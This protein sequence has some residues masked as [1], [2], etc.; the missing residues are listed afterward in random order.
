MLH[1]A[2]EETKLSSDIHRY[3]KKVHDTGDGT[4]ST[5]DQKQVL[6][7]FYLVKKENDTEENEEQEAQ[8][9][10]KKTPETIWKRKRRET[11][12]VFKPD[13]QDVEQIN[14]RDSPQRTSWLAMEKSNP[15]RSRRRRRTKRGA[16]NPKTGLEI[17]N[18]KPG[19]ERAG[20]EPNHL[21]SDDGCKLKP[22]TKLFRVY[23]AG[24][25]RD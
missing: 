14:I 8:R 11:K 5:H 18:L 15:G 3:G 17:P 16:F 20:S 25:R 24:E 9:K 7:A 13:I 12:T 10:E 19:P 2:C 21:P 6:L 4:I 1:I 23:W 22:R